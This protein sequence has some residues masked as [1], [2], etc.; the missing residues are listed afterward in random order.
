[1]IAYFVKRIQ[2]FLC[3]FVTAVT[4]PCEEG[5]FSTQLG[6]TGAILT[7]SPFTKRIEESSLHYSV[8]F[9]EQLDRSTYEYDLSQRHLVSFS[10]GITDNIEAGALF[11]FFTGSMEEENRFY[12]NLKYQMPSATLPMAFSVI[13]PGSQ[14][15]YSSAMASVG[16]NS[17]YFGVGAN[18]GGR[19]LEEVN[20][21][22]LNNFGSA[23]FGGYRLRSVI[24]R[25]GV[26]P[27]QSVVEGEPDPIFAFAGGQI[28][29]APNLQFV[30]DFNGDIVASG[31]RLTMDTSTFQI[32]WVS[33]GDYD[34]L[35]DRKQNN[36]IASAQYK[37]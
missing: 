28:P 9:F 27:N 23:L 12:W 17:F 22:T 16:W 25:Q 3:L 21:T 30:Y 19:K 24:D 1:M 4:L 26:Q 14:T 31:F 2:I 35:W 18:F 32:N 10:S 37:F 29:V 36:I 15:D 6:L 20:L 13:V 8:N 11:E 33:K 5:L 7:P 34:T